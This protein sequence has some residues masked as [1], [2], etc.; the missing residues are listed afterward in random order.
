MYKKVILLFFYLTN[1]V[2]ASEEY[3]LTLRN[4]TV[5]LRQG[6]SFEYPIKIFYKK[7]YLPVLIQDKS[8]NFKKIRD[9]ENNSGW[10]HVSQLSKKN[11]AITVDKNVMVF[12]NPT[13]YSKP[14]LILEKGK[15]C[16]VVK[17]KNEWCKIKVDRYSGWIKKESLWGRY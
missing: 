16:L 14:L 12:K 4:D 1:F 8:G 3:F 5:N 15:L 9:H 17:C 2:L 7:K 10:I 13:L 11:A 6:P